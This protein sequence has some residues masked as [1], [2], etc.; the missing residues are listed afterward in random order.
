LSESSRGQDSRFYL[1]VKG[2]LIQTVHALII[3]KKWFMTVAGKVELCGLKVYSRPWYIALPP[4]FVGG[5]C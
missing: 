4:A 2:L 5:C 3:V 1:D